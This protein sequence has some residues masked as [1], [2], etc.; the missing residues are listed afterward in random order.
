M[1]SSKLTQVLVI[2]L[3]LCGLF[4]VAA[5]GAPVPA[6]KLITLVAGGPHQETMETQYLKIACDYTLNKD[7]LKLSGKLHFHRSITM[8]YPGLKLFYMEAIFLNAQGKV[9]ERTNIS[10]QNDYVWGHMEN[11]APASFDIQL[12][13][14]PQTTA[15]TFYYNGKTQ[16]EVGAMGIS[17]YFDPLSQEGG[18]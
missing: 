12:T 7:Q 16:S 18:E 2:S 5:M 10:L 13:V 15:M 3:L 14:P 11:P 1:N 9:L 4:T 8:N 6:N 17:F